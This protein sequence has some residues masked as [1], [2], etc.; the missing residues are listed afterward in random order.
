MTN[1]EDIKSSKTQLKNIDTKNI[2]PTNTVTK[3][4]E[5]KK[6]DAS[7]NNNFINANNIIK[8][9][10]KVTQKST[11]T[12]SMNGLKN[13][14]SG[15]NISQ[16]KN[17]ITLESNV[18][19]ETIT[20]QIDGQNLEYKLEKDK[21]FV[22][23]YK[24]LFGDNKTSKLIY[25]NTTVSKFTTLNGINYDFN[26][27]HNFTVKGDVIVKIKSTIEIKVNVACNKS[28][29]VEVNKNGS[30]DDLL[31][32]C[33]EKHNIENRRIFIN[34]RIVK[35]NEMINDLLEENDVIDLISA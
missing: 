35:K 14:K 27:K 24:F 1:T 17:N 15:E 28:F 7:N 22:N 34:G 6:S 12:N 21:N 16:D 5:T 32:T 10:V 20:I 4:I 30:F 3:N 23:L 26:E 18:E 8:G 13:K 25:K 19:Y 2:Q 11:Q 9:N 31:K 33:S 29:V